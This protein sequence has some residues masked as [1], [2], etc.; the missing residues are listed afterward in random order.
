MSLN[1][2]M[3]FPKNLLAAGIWAVSRH[4]VRVLA[5]AV[6][7][8]RDLRQVTTLSLNL[9]HTVNDMGEKLLT[10]GG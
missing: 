5:F 7:L 9:S 1:R 8:L 2:V 4:E 3:T 6:H 10:R